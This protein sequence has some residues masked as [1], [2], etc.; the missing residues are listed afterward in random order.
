[1][2]TLTAEQA[3]QIEEA[4]NSM[5]THMGMDED[6]WTKPTFNQA[7]EALATIRAARAQEQAEQEPLMVTPGGGAFPFVEVGYVGEFVAPTE[8]LPAGTPLCVAPVEP[9]KQGVNQELNWGNNKFMLNEQPVKQKSAAWKCACG[10]NL[11]IDSNGAPASKAEQVGQHPMDYDQGFVDGVEAQLAEQ[12]DHEPVAKVCHDLPSHIG[13]NPNLAVNEF[14]EGMFLYTRPTRT[15]DLTD[16]EIMEIMKQPFNQRE[17][18]EQFARAVIAKD[19]EKN[20]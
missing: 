16:E 7:R 11:Y 13:W 6:E 17:Y 19:R 4:F 15:K 14:P 12:A 8:S 18:L 3:Q 2:I 20:K 5:L 1:M 9:M 10:A